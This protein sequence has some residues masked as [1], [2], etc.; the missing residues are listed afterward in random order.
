MLAHLLARDAQRGLLPSPEATSAETMKPRRET[1][2]RKRTGILGAM[3]ACAHPT[4]LECRTLFR[5]TCSDAA[6]GK[7][8]SGCKFGG[9]LGLA[10]KH[11]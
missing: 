11:L 9:L 8:D 3:S 5:T 6:S 2:P 4:V 1:S 7:Q 10:A